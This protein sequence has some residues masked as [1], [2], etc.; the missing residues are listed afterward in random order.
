MSVSDVKAGKAFVELYAKDNTRGGIAS[1][2]KGLGDLASGI[3]L[4]AAVAAVAG[5][6]SVLRSVVAA[7]RGDWEGVEEVIKRIP[8]GIGP[9][10]VQVKDLG[11]ELAQIV[12]NLAAGK[13]PAFDPQAATDYANSVEDRVDAL[14]KM[15]AEMTKQAAMDRAGPQGRARL[16]AEETYK[17]RMDAINAQA[18]GLKESWHG[19]GWVEKAK[20]AAEA[21]KLAAL[22]KAVND[23]VT[24]ATEAQRT[25]G[26]TEAQRTAYQL[27]QGGASDAAVKKARL[28][29]EGKE[30]AA[31]VADF[32]EQNKTA[33]DRQV[34]Q[35][36]KLIDAANREIIT[37][38]ELA[39]M[40]ATLVVAGPTRGIFGS[41]A[42]QSLQGGGDSPAAR[43]AKAT[44]ATARAAQET[45]GN[46]RQ[47]ARWK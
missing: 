2:Q 36:A 9:L 41:A 14:K 12:A 34:E 24:A 3:R 19:G 31:F 17:K 15:T 28:A 45:A 33:F 42:I 21:E 7:L 23:V 47:T 37:P 40:M 30:L 27:T 35:T 32:R 16:K 43:T 6:T 46:T 44:E 26:M 13:S 20:A 39:A 22:G 1:A 4:G 18:G 11:K 8:M 10:L 25:A 38:A 29:V 5:G